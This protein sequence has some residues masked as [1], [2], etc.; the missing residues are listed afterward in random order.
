MLLERRGT[1]RAISKR[2]GDELFEALS[3]RV[4][5]ARSSLISLLYLGRCKRV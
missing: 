2:Q 1:H 4:G 3:R 5:Y